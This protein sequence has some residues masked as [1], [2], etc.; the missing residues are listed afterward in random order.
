M[1]ILPSADENNLCVSTSMRTFYLDVNMEYDCR[2]LG[3]ILCCMP[4]LQRFIIT[5]NFSLSDPSN[6]TDLLNGYEWYKLLETHMSHINVLDIFIYIMYA[7][8][9][10]KILTMLCI[11]LKTFQKNM[12]IG[13]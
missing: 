13:R 12:M 6:T 9:Y 2:L 1:S 4:N 11:H 5:F 10:Q 3:P 7:M 8:L